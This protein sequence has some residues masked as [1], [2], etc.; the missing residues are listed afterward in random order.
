M[1]V[2]LV[3]PDMSIFQDG[4]LWIRLGLSPNVSS[5]PSSAAVMKV[6]S[7]INASP[8]LTTNILI[9]LRIGRDRCP[10]TGINRLVVLEMRAKRL[11]LRK[12]CN[13]IKMKEII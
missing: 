7:L 3:T 5:T 9:C 4:N 2:A 8:T 11:L 1:S 12:M 10:Q 6:M 13:H